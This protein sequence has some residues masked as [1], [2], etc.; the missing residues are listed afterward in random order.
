MKRLI[1]LCFLAIVTGQHPEHSNTL[2][3]KYSEVGGYPATGFHVQRSAKP[4]GPYQV[5]ATIHAPPTNTTYI[6]SDVSPGQ[7]W[8]YV[9]TSFNSKGESKPS[10]EINLSTPLQVPNP[11]MTLTGTAK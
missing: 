8:Y 9:V 11:P 6:D 10:N 7:V 1:F 5:V 2:T 3:W 4:G